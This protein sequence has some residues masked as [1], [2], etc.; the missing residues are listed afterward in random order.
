M[1]AWESIQK[2]LD[3]IETRISEKI[4]VEELACAASL[5]VFY[6]QRLFSRLVKR[7]VMEYIKLRRLAMA[8][9]ALRDTN[10][11]IL[12]IALAYG[13][14]GHEVF[15]RTFKNA[16]GITPT[17]YRESDVRLNV[18]IKPNL[19]MGYTLIDLDVPLIAEGLVL[20]MNRRT[21]TAPIHFMGVQG[22]AS[23]AKQFP[24][25]EAT[26]IS[27]PGEIWRLFNEAEAQ[28]PNKPNGRKI[29]VAYHGDAPAGSFSYFVGAEV[30]EG[31]SH[32]NYKIWTLPAN[33]YLVMR[34]E[35]ETFDELVGVALNKA[36]KYQ[37]MW[38]AQKGLGF[39]D[40]GAEVYYSEADNANGYTFMEMWSLWIE[41]E[42]K[43]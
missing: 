35:A 5:S 31:V 40:F 16:Y 17:E 1:H 15:T 43:Q 33:E 32:P 23:I 8:C 28:I 34:F 12:D 3:I 37:Y 18:F 42:E 24:N 39:A 21:L 38:Q 26:G 41:K 13:F 4:T 20:E 6:Y 9:E 22:Y 25:G 10:D 14:G 36:L 27:E 29:G 19:A 7:P 11:R 2:T 30:E